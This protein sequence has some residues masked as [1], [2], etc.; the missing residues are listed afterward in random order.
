MYQGYNQ[1]FT[2]KT[3]PINAPF[4]NFV[5]RKQWLQVMFRYLSFFDDKQE[6]ISAVVNDITHYIFL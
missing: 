2:Q 4:V 5:N 1:I 6:D 3:L